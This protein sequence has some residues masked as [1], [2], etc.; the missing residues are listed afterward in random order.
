MD[1]RSAGA[2]R[3]AVP[4]AAAPPM[5]VASRDA[6]SVG[7]PLDRVDGRLKVTG[8]A[9]YS[10]EMPVHG[11]AH[12]VM[13]QSTIA[14]G[15]IA[16]LD[17][18][19]AE[20]APGVLAVMTHLNAPRLPNG[21]HPPVAPPA[22]RVLTLLQDDAVHY[23]GQPIAV[24]VAETFE[25]A[26]Y[27]ASLVRA[28]YQPRRAV[29]DPH[30]VLARARM[31]HPSGSESGGRNQPDTNRGD[32]VAGLSAADVQLE[33]RYTTPAE[34]HN[35]IEPHATIAVW[36]GDR[37]TLYDSTQFVSGD[38]V[39]VAKVLGIPPEQV[40]VVSLFIG[41]GF[42][43]KGST[44]SHVPLAAMAARQVKRPV[45]L[46]LTRRQMFGPVGG[47]P[48]TVQRVILGAKRDG[49]LTA[50]GHHSVSHT[51]M[52]EDWLE[53]AAVVTRMLYACP[54]VATSHRLVAVD[55]G[56][57]TFQR[58]PGEATGTYALESAMDELAVQLGIDPVEFRLKNYAE[59]EPQENKPW[60]SKSLRECYRV[61][62]ERFGWSKRSPKP[63]SMR[64]G[65]LLV[66]YGMATATYPTNRRPASALVRLARDPSGNVSALIQCGT[67][68]LGT[69]TYTI[70]TQ[71]AAD[72][73][74]LRP[75]QL[76]CEIGDSTFPP[77]P[78]SGGSMTAASAGSAVKQAALD[79]RGQLVR[80]A[81]GDHRSP[82]AGAREDDVRSD[83]GHLFIGSDP[84]KRESYTDLL[85]RHGD[86]ALEGR[87]S[88]LGPGP[89]KDQYAM[90]AF[91]AVFTEVHVDPELGRIR[92]PRVV[93]AYAAG[94]M[95]NAKTARSQLMGG[96]VWGLS[97]ALQEQS[98]IDPH[99]GRIV[100]ADLA[101]YHVPVNADV[102]D[103]DIL[104]VEED[105]PHVN[106]VGAKGIG[107]IGITGMP[108]AV[109]NAIY[110]A[111][112]T[113]V[114]GLPITL[115]KLLGVS[116]AGLRA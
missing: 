55:L 101:E 82:L 18:R 4:P 104:L 48:V 110:H 99:T 11:L 87:A 34:N 102:G 51:S 113:R 86:R 66:G 89:E 28:T 72:A 32:V 35:P 40:R 92:V 112:G 20:R 68:D 77:S 52:I 6:P 7:A 88:N 75:E 54:N 29:V 41:G 22:M 49:T 107:E 10:A 94:R 69:G 15:R 98:L 12:A 90:H 103:I 3:L 79:A 19:A 58:A 100:N 53:P 83:D 14:S 30:A 76:R 115:D 71:I 50:I 2:P 1:D 46:V 85:G 39:A 111:T 31:P 25:Q 27:A 8:G 26:I 38:G 47:R 16:K 21:G 108:A 67:Q 116:Q 84:A 96:V 42:G 9:R 74:G 60:S 78:V 61:A 109:A 63:R 5:D 33:Q 43:C 73:L 105:D 56:T 45:K 65:D 64:Q 114:R 95:L 17:V 44:W 81:L 59:R 24:V 62:A 36:E 91:G 97:M 23:N 80:L 93:A 13:V 57:P 37:L 70:L 106:P